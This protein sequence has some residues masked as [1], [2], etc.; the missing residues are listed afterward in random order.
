MRAIRVEKP[1][2]GHAVHW[3]AGDDWTF[4]GRRVPAMLVVDRLDLVTLPIGGEGCDVCEELRR[5][6]S[7]RMRSDVVLPPSAGVLRR[8]GPL[9]HGTRSRT[10][11]R[12]QFD[13]WGAS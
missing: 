7:V 10:G 6:P 4:C 13:E 9:Y 2:G 12:L 11:E 3:L 1:S 5:H 8:T